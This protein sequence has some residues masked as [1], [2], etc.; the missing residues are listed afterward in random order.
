MKDE[1]L[2]TADAARAAKHEV[3]AKRWGCMIV[4][5]SVYRD[6]W[7]NHVVEIVF[8]LLLYA[9][10]GCFVGFILGTKTILGVCYG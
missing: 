6:A 2:E 1:T 8:L 10:G 4:D 3:K 5:Y 9:A 7:R